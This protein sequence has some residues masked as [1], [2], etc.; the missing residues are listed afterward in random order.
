[1]AS[2]SGEEA[3]TNYARL[4]CDPCRKGKRRCDRALPCCSLC[5]RKNGQCVYLSRRRSRQIRTE[6]RLA[7]PNTLSSSGTNISRPDSRVDR[8]LSQIISSVTP[9]PALATPAAS[10]E[11][12]T[13]T[14][15][16][17]IA[18]HIFRQAQLELPRIHPSIPSD[19]SPFENDPSR[20]RNIAYTFFDSIHWWMPIIS[21]RGF[22]AHL[23]N[24]LSQRRSELGLLIICMQLYCAPDLNP[25]TA[26]LDVSALYHNAKRLHF[27]ME[28][29]GVLSLRVLQAGILIA[30]YEVGQAIYP[31]AYLTVGACARY[32]IV[33]GVNNLREESSSEYGSRYSMSEVDERRRAWWTI[34]FLD[35]FLNISNPSRPLATKNPTFD[36]LLP[37]DDKLW[38]DGTAKP[39]DAFKISQGFSLKMGMFSRLGQATYMLSQALDLFSPENHQNVTERNQQIA[40]LRRTLHALIKV[41]DTEA[42][43]RELRTCAG[44]CPQ[45]SIC[46]STLFMLQEYQWANGNTMDHV[47]NYVSA[48]ETADETLSTLDHLAATSQGFRDRMMDTTSVLVATPFLAHVTY[49]ATSFLIRLGRGE[50]DD[51]ATQRISL[52]KGLLQDVVPR[53]KMA[54][55][56]LDILDAQE[57]TTAS[58]AACGPRPLSSSSLDGFG[59]NHAKPPEA[60]FTARSLPESRLPQLQASAPPIRLL[61]VTGPDAAKFLQGIIT[62]NVVSSK[63]EPRTDAFYTGFLNATGRVLHDVFI[64][65]VRGAPGGSA[66]EG[67]GFLIEVDAAQIN[68][69]SKYI[70]RYKL[71]AKVAFRAL[72]SGEISVWHAWND[73]PGSQLNITPNESRIVLEDP[74]AP[75]L[76]YRIIQLAGQKAPEVDIDQTSEDAYTIR[77]YL[78]G[79]AEG[80]DEIL[81]EQALPLESNME[82]MNGVDFH[83]GCY[84][85]QELTIRTKHRGVVRKRIL[86]CVIYD[87]AKAAP[88]SLVYEPESGSP[89]T[90]TADMIPTETSIGRSGKRGRSAGKWLRGVGNVGLGLCRLEIMTD[91]VLPGEQAAATFRDG[92]EFELEWGEEENKSGVKVKAFVPEWLRQSLDAQQR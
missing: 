61:S 21:K 35:R 92:D 5:R 17:F 90:L 2:S 42:A 49:Q 3:P 45:L 51:V 22:F 29:A 76:G 73:T 77:R 65:P 20:I 28:A 16:Y 34:L 1:M 47:P 26:A 39:S 58:E 12:A 19:L 48:R 10:N 60:S 74:R 11:A 14:A 78:H 81:R 43:V 7:T 82:Y 40:Q 83:K 54:R 57:I 24:P 6:G 44:L 88:P 36:D 37:V 63:G 33:L 87:K 84:V 62:A 68:A 80:Q 8:Q 64:Y 4:A 67:D 56:Y 30:L 72:E 59:A 38:D 66:Q 69:L 32:G 55:V 79:V 89:E 85:G 50:P 13:A 91:V 25:E 70:K 86:P 46:S 23:L 71:R 41:S 9:V 27:E 18:P 31:A 52:F 53:W 75:G 15:I